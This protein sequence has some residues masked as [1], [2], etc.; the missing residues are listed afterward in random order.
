[1]T[2]GLDRQQAQQRAM[3]QQQM[4]QQQLQQQ[5]LLQQQQKQQQMQQ[6]QMQ[7]QQQ[8][9]PPPPPPQANPLGGPLGGQ[10]PAQQTRPAGSIRFVLVSILRNVSSTNRLLTRAE[11]LLTFHASK[12]TAK[13]PGGGGLFNEPVRQAPPAQKTNTDLLFGRAKARPRNPLFGPD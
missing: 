13:Q 1:M 7:Q 9:Q 11:K 12:N 10:V 8:R 5:Q 2:G 4:Q 3:Q 6:Q